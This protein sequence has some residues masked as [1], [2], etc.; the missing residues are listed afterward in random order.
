[1]TFLS[2]LPARGA[3]TRAT[4]CKQR[5][6]ISIHAP[7]EGSDPRCT[8]RRPASP[9]D[10][11]PRSPR[12]E[13]PQKGKRGSGAP[14]NFYPRSPRGER[15]Q[16]PTAPGISV[17]FLSTL[18]A[19]GATNQTDSFSACPMD[20]YPRSPRGERQRP[21]PSLALGGQFLSTLPARGA[22]VTVELPLSILLFLSTLPARGATHPHGPPRV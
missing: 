11:Y 13:R 22:T 12:G 1:M 14:G 15:H 3:A 2:T 10:F 20:F 7:R 9:P 5:W 19:R 6:R 4:P 21:A 16:P 17:E 18:P 8:T